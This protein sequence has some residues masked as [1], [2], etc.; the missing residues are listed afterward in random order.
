MG[1]KY[2]GRGFF[3]GNELMAYAAKAAGASSF[4]AYPGTPSSE[5][6][7]SFQKYAPERYAQ[8]AL[9]EKL[10]LELAAAAAI[11]GSVSAC[12]MKQ[13]GLN[14]A[15][16]PLFSVAYTGVSGALAII[17]ADDPGPHSSQTEQDSRMYAYAAKIPVTDPANPAD[18]FRLT[19]KAFEISKKY[20]VPVMVRPVM[21][22]CHSRQSFDL[23][24][25]TEAPRHGRFVK[26]PSRWAAT[27]KHR[28]ALH[29]KLT[30][31]LKE[32]A[33]D[34]Y[35]ELEIK[36]KAPFAVVA[37]GYPAAVCADMKDRFEGSADFIK[38]DMPYPIPEGL[39]SKIENSY[40]KILVLEETFPL[41]ERSFVTRNRVYGKDT[42]TVPSAGEFTADSCE[43]ALNLFMEKKPENKKIYAP[44]ETAP[45]PKPRLCAGCGH[46]SAFFAIKRAAPSGIYPG[47]IGCY[48]LGT[49]LKAVDTC[50]CMG[51]SITFAES[52]KRENPEKP[53]ICTIGDSTF[54]H[55]G[56]PA[57]L[58]AKINGSPIA[59]AILDNAT[60][61]MTGFQPVPHAEGHITIEQT[62]KGLGIN[63]VTVIDPYD[64]KASVA[65][66]K[67]AIAAAKEENCPAVVIFRRE[68]VTKTKMK[69]GKPPKVN[70]GCTDCGMCYEVFECPAITFNGE[71]VEIDGASCNGCLCCVEVCPRGVIAEDK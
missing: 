56:I 57:L 51:A 39:I 8:W 62:L 26:D 16:D 19:K 27:P 64:I 68:C 67:A 45:G 6:L 35:S 32:I 25:E 60:T 14:V 34:F 22:V 2:M 23:P 63:S 50:I 21:R 41:L 52:L 69:A 7:S 38:L 30:E 58:N 4:Y 47:D 24:E 5:I 53:V 10:A 40:E 42:G 71:T 11:S 37:C 3:L 17:S 65:A 20:G 66:V 59:V 54:F 48:T 12:A 46:R 31:K 36:P 1:L 49:N 15:A 43:N 33:E 70:P 9:N 55:T 29:I 44:A 28:A 13:V 61:A 18:A